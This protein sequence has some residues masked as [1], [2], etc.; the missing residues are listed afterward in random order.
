MEVTD[1]R[2]SSV[3]KKGN[4]RAYVTIV[5][6][7]QFMVHDLRIIERQEGGYFI[8]MPST[9]TPDGSFR[10]IAHPLNQDFRDKITA[11][12]LSRFPPAAS[13]LQE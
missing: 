2:I 3:Q 12:I 11:A 8:A 10:D 7:N 13:A 4:L 1:V 5:L 9:L 6:D